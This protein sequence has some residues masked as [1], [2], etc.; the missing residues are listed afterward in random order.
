MIVPQ[1]WAEA[2]VQEKTRERQVT[3]RRYGW[4]DASQEEAQAMA[5]TRA[6]E[7]LRRILA[8]EEIERREPKV[9]YN[10]AEGMPIREEIVARHGDMIITRNS[11]GARCLNTPDV[12][13]A[14]LDFPEEGDPFLT[15]TAFP[16]ALVMGITIGALKGSIPAALMAVAVLGVTLPLVVAWCYKIYIRA[17]GGYEDRTLR[18]IDTFSE[19][20]PGWHLRVYQTPAGFRVLAMHDTFDPAGEEAER[21]FRALGTDPVYARMCTNQRCFRARVSPKPWRIGISRHL[22]PSPGVW[23]IAPEKIPARET[24][25]RDYEQRATGHA[26]CHF[27][28]RLGSTRVHAAAE[29]VAKLHDELSRA[30]SALPIA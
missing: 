22:K 24:W 3:V 9:P 13:F 21:C 27:V 4:S 30:A 1:F 2:R 11:Y 7:V 17:T 28:K 16:I 19:R 20:N 10:G 26:A 18:R 6:A 23:P 29:Q 8:G 15:C 25:V 12:L 14:D 5:D